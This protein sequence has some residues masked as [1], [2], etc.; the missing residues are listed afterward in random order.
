MGWL[1]FQGE[2][3]L[4]FRLRRVGQPLH[5]WYRDGEPSHH[6]VEIGT[7][8]VDLS[9]AKLAATPQRALGQG[10]YT[11]IQVIARYNFITGFQ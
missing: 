4:Y 7:L 2:L 3:E 11:S 6:C 1:V 5:L 8:T 10:R 9:L